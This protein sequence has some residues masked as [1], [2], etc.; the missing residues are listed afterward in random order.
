LAQNTL[1]VKGR[2]GDPGWGLEKLTSKS[3]TGMNLHKPNEL[4]SA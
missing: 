1:A 3:I 4:I 2:V